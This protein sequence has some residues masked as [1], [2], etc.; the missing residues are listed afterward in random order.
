MLNI[1]R[2]GFVVVLLFISGCTSTPQTSRYYLLESLAKNT[3]L[4]ANQYIVLQ[5]IE[6][7]DYIKSLNLHIKAEDGEVIYSPLDLW[8]EQPSKMIWRVMQQSLEQ[9]TGRYV[10][11]SFDAP[12]GCVSVSFQFD[13]LSPITTGQ[14]VTRGRWIIKQESKTVYTSNF[15]YSDPIDSDGFG[16]ANRVTASHLHQLASELAKKLAPLNTCS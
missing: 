4:N 14:V 10:S 3:E 1:I 12:K 15:L 9:Q 8:A 2:T 6:L 11:R 13:E 5:T 16:T 7:A